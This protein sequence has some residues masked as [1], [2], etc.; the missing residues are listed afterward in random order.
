MKILM[1]CTEKLPV[2]PIL[3]GAIQTYISGVLPHLKNV[4]DITVLGISDAI[5]TGSRND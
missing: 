3:G 4:H 5:A 2:P 1:I